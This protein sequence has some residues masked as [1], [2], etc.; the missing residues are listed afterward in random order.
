M[1]SLS[2][3]PFVLTLPRQQQSREFVNPEPIGQDRAHGLGDRQVDIVSAA[4][5]EH[6]RGGLHALG[7]LRGVF[8]DVLEAHPLA[9]VAAEGAIA[10][11]R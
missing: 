9:E 2:R 6:G 5:R 11:Q 10:R 4:Q 8:D 3:G 1:C 7:R